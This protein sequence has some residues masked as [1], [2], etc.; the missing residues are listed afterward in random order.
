MN[1]FFRLITVIILLSG[2]IIFLYPVN[3]K[4]KQFF[5]LE[6]DKL[7]GTKAPD[8]TLK[9]ISGKDVSLSSFKGKPVLLNF[10]A[11]WCPYCREERPLL[12]SLYKEYK[13]KGLIIVAV[14]TDKSAQKVKDYLKKMPM[15][16]TLLIDNGK[17]AE[18]YGVYA[19]PT[20]FLINRDGAI[21]QK[22]MG[23][24]DWTNNSSKKIIN[25]LLK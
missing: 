11:T 6:I 23:A 5:P 15:E 4:A 1:K 2:F 25:E 10:W 12:N 22:F 9:D 8:F 20:S 24:R 3:I 21:K 7:T 18:I 16:F 19:L 13:N 14:S 17:I